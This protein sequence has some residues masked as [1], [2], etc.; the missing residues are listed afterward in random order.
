MNVSYI[1]SWLTDYKYKAVCDLL[2]YGFPIGLQHEAS[3][4]LNQSEGKD[5]CEIK[6]T[7]KGAEEFPDK[8]NKS[9]QE[10]TFN[11]AVLG[12]FK[13]NPFSSGIKI[14]SL[15]SLSEKDTYERKVILDLSFPKEFAVNDFISKEEYLG[16]NMEIVFPKV[17]DFIQIIKTKGQACLLF[18]KIFVEHTGKYLFVLLV[19]IQLILSGEILYFLYSFIYGLQISCILLSKSYKCYYI[20]HV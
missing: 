3:T 15:N 14:S 20:Y 16:G 13:K 7:H 9:F 6:K 4:V 8:M 11:K 12:S 5:I 17:D 10:E 19:I 1:R 18:K 2:E